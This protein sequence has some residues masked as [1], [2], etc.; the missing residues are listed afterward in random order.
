MEVL[1]KF[2]VAISRATRSFPALQ[3]HHSVI[4]YTSAF[5]LLY[6]LFSLPTSMAFPH[7]YYGQ[8]KTRLSI[9]LPG[10]AYTSAVEEKL[11]LGGHRP[12]GPWFVRVSIPIPGVPRR[13]ISL[14]IPNPRLGRRRGAFVLFA[15]LVMVIY[16]IFHPRPKDDYKP[17]TPP[18]WPTE[19][20]KRNSVVYKPEDLQR[21]WE[22]EIQSGHYPSRR[23]R[24]W[25]S[26]RFFASSYRFSSSAGQSAIRGATCQS[27][28]ATFTKKSGFVGLV[29]SNDERY[30][31][32]TCLP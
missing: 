16:A 7:R 14:W 5:S 21:I 11:R 27:R 31:A 6:H 25:L 26:L 30:W 17:W 32:P 12:P 13:A 10:P 2:H 23:K 3:C 19:S 20:T 8:Q 4:T 15:V 29:F 1:P 28:P 18:S 9:G 24:T 22:W